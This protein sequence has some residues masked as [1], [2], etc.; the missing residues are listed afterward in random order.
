MFLELIF[1][2]ISCILSRID[3][4]IIFNSLNKEHINKIIDIEM[5]D[6]LKR[7]MEIG[8]SVKI[9]QK[10]KDFIAEKGFDKNFGAR[11]LKR[12]IQK[13]FEDPLAEEIIHSNIVEGDSIKVDLNKEGDKL[14][15][16]LVKQKKKPSAKKKEKTD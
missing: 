6:I 7:I 2:A 9:S 13:Y 1:S 14:V 4:V 11:P 16:K 15:M 8:Y 10:A 12:A 5:K 3:D